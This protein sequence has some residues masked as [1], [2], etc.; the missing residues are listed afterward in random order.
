[1]AM[2]KPLEITDLTPTDERHFTAQIT[3]KLS[4]SLQR[5][6]HPINLSRVSRIPPSRLLQSALPNL[7]TI[8]LVS[9][10]AFATDYAPLYTSMFHGFERERPDLI[11]ERLEQDFAG[12]R[13]G[14]FPYRIIGL[15]D[16]SGAAIGAAQF[17]VLLLPESEDAVPY[18]QYIYVR[19]ENRRQDLSELLHTLVL[20]VSMTEGARAAGKVG[21]EGPATVNVPFTLFETEPPCHGV[22]DGARATAEERTR[23]HAKSGSMAMMLRRRSDGR[24]L[25]AHVQ[26][27]LEVGDPHLTLVWVVR[28]NPGLGDAAVEAEKMGSA[29]LAACYR[30]FRDEGFPEDNIALA[31]RLA[32]ERREGAEFCLLPLKDVTRGM[33]VGID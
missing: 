4:P 3:S 14:L 30:S 18:L 24:Y 5:L 16:P 27:G 21:D 7:G 15:R 29:A 22:D 10:A 17:S 23:I 20:A 9:G 33:Y 1:M 25:S 2:A 31:E 28:P 6:L 11:I 26:P 13:Q 32:V 8:E 12:K 19:P